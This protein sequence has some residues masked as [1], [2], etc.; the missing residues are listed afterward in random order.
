[1]HDEIE[2]ESTGATA[3][4][5]EGKRLIIT[6]A[7]SGI[8]RATSIMAAAAGARVVA[9]DLAEAVED[10]VAEIR[11][12]GG[13]AVAQ[14]ADVSDEAAVTEC[15]PYVNG[16]AVPVDGGLSASHPWVYPRS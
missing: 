8:G 15:A 10:T 5:L 13:E 9:V 7:A 12:A 16:Q 14:R 11:R 6:G 1:M 4:E 2:D 3:R